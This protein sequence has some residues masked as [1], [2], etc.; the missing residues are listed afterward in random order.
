MEYVS[1]DKEPATVALLQGY[2]PNQGDG[3]GYTLAYLE[4]FL[5]APRQQTSR[6]A[7]ISR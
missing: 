5:E 1:P 4:R 6:T 2:V 3:W 7:A